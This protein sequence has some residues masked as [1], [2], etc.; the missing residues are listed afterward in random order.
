MAGARRKS[1]SIA[2]VEEAAAPVASDAPMAEHVEAAARAV[3]SPGERVRFLSVAGVSCEA[4]VIRIDWVDG[5]ELRV[6][7]PSGLTFV[8]YAVEGT[9]PGTFQRGV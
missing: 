8:T 4:V 7:K 6:R 3:V 1:K 2:D 9:E 5:I